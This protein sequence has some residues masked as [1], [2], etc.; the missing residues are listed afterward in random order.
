[1]L[2]MALTD[3]GIFPLCLAIGWMTTTTANAPR[4]MIKKHALCSQGSLGETYRW[5]FGAL[6]G[7][8][9]VRGGYGGRVVPPPMWLA[10]WS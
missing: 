6:A 9:S 4:N 7:R 8:R 10:L 3:I 5:P 2:E 1:M